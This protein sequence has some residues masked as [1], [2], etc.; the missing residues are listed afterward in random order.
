MANSSVNLLSLDFA[1]IK[2]DFVTFLRSKD[3]FKDYDYE[4]SNMNMLIELLSYNTYKNNFYTNMVGSEMFLDSAQLKDSV[5]SHSKILNYIPRSFKSAYAN[6]NFV[7]TVPIGLTQY[8]LPKGTN[9]SSRIAANSFVFSTDETIVIN[10]YTSNTTSNISTF[11][12]NFYIYEGGYLTD[13]FIKQSGTGQRF[14]LSNFRIDTSSITVSVIEDGGAYVA[15]YFPKD[16]LFDLNATSEVYFL[17]AAENNQYEILFGDGVVGK[18]PKDGA[19]IVVEYRVSSGE[20]PNGA[21]KFTVMSSLTGNIAITTLSNAIG[22]AVSESISSIKYN[23]PRHF[24]RQERVITTNDYENVLIQE[25]PEIGAITAFGGEDAIPPQYGKVF[26][27]IKLKDSIYIPESRKLAYTQYL[28]DKS[29]LTI[30][31]VIVEPKNLYIEVQTIVNY[32]VNVTLLSIQDIKS[33]VLDKIQTFNTKYLEN[34]KSELKF[35][36]LVSDI[37]GSHESIVSNITTVRAFKKIAPVIGIAT[38]Y[39]FSFEQPLVNDK[40]PVTKVHESKYTL[41]VKSSQFTYKGSECVLEDDGSGNLNIVTQV[42]DKYVLITKTG[43]VNYDTGDVA[44][45]NLEISKFVGDTFNVYGYTRTTNIKTKTNVILSIP[46]DS[47][48]ITV[49]AVRE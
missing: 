4:G 44:I 9:F 8:V 23:A 36:K 48:G 14:I 40:S 43:T 39:S 37:D 45:N 2:Q 21:S 11:T 30:E 49:N 47:I 1:E 13:T 18:I 5:V 22:G 46:T 29:P 24:Q 25:F 35:S 17:Q 3:G 31:A 20:L 6:I 7:A 41:A 26:V 28:M 34:F 19:T 27:A 42:G 12:G 33:L 38:N 10:E 15:P 16:T 32:N